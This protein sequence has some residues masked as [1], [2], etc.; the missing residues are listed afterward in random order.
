VNKV[1]TVMADDALKN[2]ALAVNVRGM[3]VSSQKVRK[4]KSSSLSGRYDNLGSR[5]FV[6]CH[7]MPDTGRVHD[8]LGNRHHVK[9]EAELKS[10]ILTLYIIRFVQHN[11]FTSLLCTLYAHPGMIRLDTICNPTPR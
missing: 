1:A 8:I 5:A 2:A 9:N 7:E 3:I 6:C 11:S 4:W 10:N